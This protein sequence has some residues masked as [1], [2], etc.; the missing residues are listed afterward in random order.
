GLGEAPGELELDRLLTAAAEQVFDLGRGPLWRV[1]LVRLP[2]VGESGRHVL[3]L[4]FHHIVIDLWSVGI[5]VRDVS[6]LYCD[7]LDGGEASPAPPPLHYADFAAWQRSWLAGPVLEAQLDYWRRQLLGAPER[8]TLP[9]TREKHD[10]AAARSVAGSADSADS[11]GGDHWLFLPPELL[12]QLEGLARDSGATLFMV[13]LAAF[14]VLLYRHTGETDL[15]LGSDFANR[16]REETEAMVGFFINVLPLR[17]DLSGSPTFKRLVERVRSTALGAHAHQD[18]PFDLLVRDQG[19]ER[20]SSAPLFRMLFVVQNAPREELDLG[21]QLTVRDR[22]VGTAT[23]KFDLAVFCDRDGDGLGCRFGYRRSSYD[24]PSVELLAARYHDLLRRVV[25]D[26]NRRIDEFDFLTD[27]EREAKTMD[28]AD[29]ESASKRRFADFQRR[30]PKAVS[31]EETPLVR[32][33]YLSPDS[34]LPRVLEPA[35]SDVDLIEWARANQDFLGREVSEHGAIL[36]RGFG[37]ESV[38]EF[39]RFAAAAAHQLFGE[40]GDLPKEKGGEKVYK[41]TP[42]PQDKRILFHNESAHMDR[43]PLRQFFFC[44]QPAE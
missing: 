25:A 13:L 35:M 36:L 19:A 7:A 14:E 22:T 31:L 3:F 30:R 4:N 2:A 34:K 24:A 32:S 26:P 5:L 29:K 39:E 41:S 37:I 27:M 38:P 43:W 17:T 20:A 6:R 44:V 8:I 9:L 11:A 40:Y 12:Q 28:G 42:Y 1:L 10:P 33:G 23:S 21:G 18:V 16:N 15:V